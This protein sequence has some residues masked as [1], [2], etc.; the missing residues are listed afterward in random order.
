MVGACCAL[1]RRRSAVTRRESKPALH[2]ESRAV[3][4]SSRVLRAFDR[5]PGNR[6]D[7][8]EIDHLRLARTIRRDRGC[9]LHSQNRTAGANRDYRNVTRR[10]SGGFGR[11]TAPGRGGSSRSCL[12]VHRSSRQESLSDE[13]RPNGRSAHPTAFAAITSPH[14]CGRKRN[15]TSRPYG[16]YVLSCFYHCRNGRPPYYGARHSS[17]LCRGQCSKATLAGAGRIS[18][19]YSARTPGRI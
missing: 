3:P 4:P 14:W 18:R 5:S 16:S 19:R 10:R 1:A 11:T 15:E 2:G 7:A 17:A 9:G 8:R 6:G 12:P 13:V